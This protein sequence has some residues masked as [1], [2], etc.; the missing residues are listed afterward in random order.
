MTRHNGK[1][2]QRRGDP[3]TGSDAP[4]PTLRD[5][6]RLAEFRYLLRRFLAFSEDAAIAAGLTPRQHQALLAIKGVPE[7]TAPNIGHLAGRLGIRPHSA[8]ELADRLA[9]AGLVVREPDMADRRRV[10]LSLTDAAERHLAALSAEHL[11][12]LHRLRPALLA[13]LEQTGET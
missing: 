3:A 6:R 1:P 11:R 9:E 10:C 8:V 12:E 13:I 5:Y 4:Q 2:P 7:G